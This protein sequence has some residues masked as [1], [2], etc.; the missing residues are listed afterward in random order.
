MDKKKIVL[1]IIGLALFI[2]FAYFFNG[3]MDIDKCL[4]NGGRW[5][6]DKEICEFQEID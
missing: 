5:N 3:Y 6:Y 1:W 4:D 2:V